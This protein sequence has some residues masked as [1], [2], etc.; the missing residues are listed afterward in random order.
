MNIRV[1]MLMQL[2]RF[3]PGGR[4]DFTL[5]VEDG[6]RVETVTAG[7]GLGPATPRITRTRPQPAKPTPSRIGKRSGPKRWPRVAGKVLV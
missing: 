4:P 6:A 5:E 2:A 3:A 1:R 7:L